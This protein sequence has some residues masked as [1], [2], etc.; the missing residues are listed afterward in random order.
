VTNP[1]YVGSLSAIALDLGRIAPQQM[2]AR[3]QALGVKAPSI[4][5]ENV[6][7]DAHAGELLSQLGMS[8][9]LRN[10]EFNRAAGRLA[11]V[12]Q[13]RALSGAIVATGITPTYLSS[14]PVSVRFD[15]LTID[16]DQDS[17][18]AVATSGEDAEIEAYMRL[19]GMQAS[20]SEAEIFEYSLG[21]EAVS[22]TRVLATA[23]AA[24]IPVHRVTSA[25]LQEELGE[26]R[27]PAHVERNIADA[28]ATA[29]V[30]VITPET[31]VTVGGWTGSGYIVSAPLSADYR[32]SGGLNG[33]SAPIPQESGSEPRNGQTLLA[34]T[35]P[36]AAEKHEEQAECDYQAIVGWFVIFLICLIAMLLIV[37]VA[38][39]G[40][41]G[42][43]AALLMIGIQT[44]GGKATGGT[45]IGV[46]ITW[47]SF[48][49]VGG[50][51]A[52]AA[53]ALGKSLTEARRCDDLRRL[54]AE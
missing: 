43:H 24:G 5:A 33:G 36:M 40:L 2:K 46:H 10:D 19:S 7:T 32:I 52:L 6:L 50:F 38:G 3:A 11:N 21:W 31:L 22:T 51:A 17:Q 12:H 45:P 8:Y 27:L 54:H 18:V 26:L 30:E 41:P 39:G 23:A 44:V 16:V 4:T 14:F 49:I 42:L 9:F 37:T 53:F 35:T 13:S 1:V 28:V 20:S 34:S 48:L 25:N 29:G 15:S 47:Q